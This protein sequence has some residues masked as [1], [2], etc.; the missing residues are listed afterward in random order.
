[1]GY[2]KREMR[3]YERM[4][5][6]IKHPKELFKFPNIEAE[7][8]EFERVADT[9]DVDTD[10]LMFLAEEASLVSLDDDMWKNLHNTDSNKFGKGDWDEVERYSLEYKRDW[11]SLKSE[12]EHG[13]VLEAPIILEIDGILHLISGNTRLMIARA[14][15][16]T[17]KVLFVTYKHDRSNEGV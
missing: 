9:F 17:P 4:N 10:S 13:G 14:F 6:S 11:K 5:E 12:I 7:R 8:G 1:M 3:Y 16:I 15:G 2:R